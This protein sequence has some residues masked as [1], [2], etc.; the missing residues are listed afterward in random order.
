VTIGATARLAEFSVKSRWEELPAAAIERAKRAILDS[1]GVMLAGS[2]EPPALIVQRLAEAEGGAPLCTVAGTRLRTGGVWAALANGTAG[3]ALDF[4]DT[5]FAM[6]GHPSVPV[7]AAALAAGELA[8]ADGRALIHAFLVGFE[9]ETTLAEAMNPGHY[10]RGWHA[11]S[12]LG[13]LGAVAASAKLLGLDPGETRHA[14]AIAASQASGLKENFG[15]MTKPFHAGHAA[16]GGVLAAL[17]AREGF[18]GSDIAIEGPQGYLRVLGS[19]TEDPAAALER[20]G[21]PW[22]ILTTGVA[23]KPYPSCA[24]THSIIA[25]L[26]ELR[27]AHAL[28]PEDV[29]EVT[30][31]VNPL[32]PGI[33]IHHDPHTGLEGK[34]SAEF[35]AAAALVDGS[36]G[37]ATFKDERIAD[38]ALRGV[39]GRVKMVVD[40]TIPSDLEHHMW[41]RLKVRLAG[42]R[43]LE[44][45]PREVPGHSNAPLSREALL[46]KFT[47]CAGRVLARDR[48]DSIAQ[49]LEG[50]EG[51]PDLRSLTAT[52]RP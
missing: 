37:I 32:V 31:G 21:A 36:V 19:Q 17:L 8:L 25:G 9:V 33:L 40:P 47:D 13:I 41:T 20:L 26:L 24:C 51:C 48:V 2:V 49:M 16:R 15:T 22:K 3:H 23:V 42:G 1:V 12:T 27:Q 30:I 6:L 43:A 4:D 38:P 18:T 14:L 28:R 35:C 29:A 39:M 34:F 52:L 7:L 10:V 50:L 11:T 45:P 5:N 46:A 44:V